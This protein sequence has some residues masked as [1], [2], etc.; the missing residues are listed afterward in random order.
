MLF[1]KYRFRLMNPET[2]SEEIQNA[3]DMAQTGLGSMLSSTMMLHVAR[4]PFDLPFVV[5]VMNI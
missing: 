2:E 5:W 1:V 3:F 4:V